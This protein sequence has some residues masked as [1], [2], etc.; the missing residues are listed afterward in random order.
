M[1]NLKDRVLEKLAYWYWEKDTNRSSD[2]NYKLAIE[3]LK[4]LEKRYKNGRK[5]RSMSNM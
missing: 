3:L 1:I 5:I 2:E 4:K